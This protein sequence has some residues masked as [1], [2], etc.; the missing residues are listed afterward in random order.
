MSAS[1]EWNWRVVRL[2]T[3]AQSKLN[4]MHVGG[5]HTNKKNKIE[6]E[7]S[8]L[9][10]ENAEDAV[11]RHF[12]EPKVFGRAKRNTTTFIGEVDGI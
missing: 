9:S 11:I 7:K 3:T 4:M 8:L 10:R 1:V 2:V 5:N 6:N 12:E